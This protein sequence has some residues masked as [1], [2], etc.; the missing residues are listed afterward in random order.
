MQIGWEAFGVIVV[1]AG[2]ILGWLLRL[3][4]KITLL[5]V[6]VS[7]LKE[8]NESIVGLSSKFEEFQ[9][10]LIRLEEKLEGLVSRLENLAKKLGR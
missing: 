8:Q 10:R 2:G 1:V 6:E 9:E 5:D 4:S 3:Q 7:H